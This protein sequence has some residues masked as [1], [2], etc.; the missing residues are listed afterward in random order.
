[1]QGLQAEMIG[2]KQDLEP[3]QASWIKYGSSIMTDGWNDM[4]QQNISSMFLLVE[5]QYL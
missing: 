1:V 3:I 5:E 2:M 4:K